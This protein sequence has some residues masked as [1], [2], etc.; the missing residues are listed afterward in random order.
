MR[1][2]PAFLALAILPGCG[3]LCDVLGLVGA[4]AGSAN[5]TGSANLKPFQSEK[6]LADYFV[7]QIESRNDTFADMRFFGMSDGLDLALGAEGAAGF[8]DPLA[9]PSA[10]PSGL[11]ETS[12]SIGPGAGFSQTTIQEVGVDEADVVKTDGN[13]LYVISGAASGSI[14][15]IIDVST[16]ANMAVLDEVNL[17]GYGSDI[18][19]HDGKI[20][21]VTQTYGQ[22]FG[23]GGP[24]IM[25]DALPAEDIAVRPGTMVGMEVAEP[26]MVAPGPTDEIQFN[27]PQTIVTVVDITTPDDATILST[28]RFDGSPSSTRLID[29]VLHLVISNFQDYYYDVLPMLGRPEMNDS[30]IETADLLPRFARSSSG[31]T[32]LEGNVVT[33]RELY[34]PTDADGFGVVTVVSLDV[35]NDAAFTAV[36][37]VAQPGLIYSSLNALYLTDTEYDFTGTVR[38]T[39]DIYKFGY[40]NRSAAPVA[41]GTVPG[42]ILNQY[43][44]SEHEGYLRVATTVSPTFGLL[45][46]RSLPTNNVYVLGVSGGT[47]SVKGRREN[48]EPGE[49]IRSARFVGDRGYMVT[50]EQ[51]DPLLTLDLSDP[52]NPLVMGKLEI[53]GFSTF[54][55]PM[56][57]DH[58]LAVGQHIPD[59]G[60]FSP[61]S[62][63]LSIFDVS[64][65]S[66]PTRTHN[67]V[68]GEM[69]GASSEALQ[70]PKALTYFAE[71]G[72]LAL[73]VSIYEDFNGFGIAIG[74]VDDGIAISP[75]TEPGTVVPI[76]PSLTD[77]SLV[78]LEADQ[79][80]G[81]SDVYVPGGFEGLVVFSVSTQDGF[82][83]LGRIST[84]FEEVGVYWSQF[85]RG[86]FIGDD[87]LAVTDNGVRG[88]PVSD[89]TSVPYQLITAPPA[90]NGRPAR[91]EINVPMTP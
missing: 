10:P 69:T 55:V 13:R 38:E 82:G 71:Q 47:L 48:I 29:G 54:L 6:E 26:G 67:V 22:F 85:T 32:I 5:E 11:T 14:L 37:V 39:T 35:D 17:D 19:L 8:G 83:E 16:R 63:Q 2:L 46:G 4:C 86:V 20:V 3:V 61:W 43:S 42:R 84:R 50:F 18:Y 1:Y 72:L 78:E 27:R 24:G 87:I 68:L 23:F 64:D 31:G 88:A 7:D 21:A 59:V 36:G 53:P 52:S 65:F 62:V 89:I 66:N 77:V 76:D 9:L 28:T 60:F 75:A 44:M 15:R 91:N 45:G 80:I 73:P 74:G 58:L 34:R 57:E 49:T 70:N 90:S 79:S 12:D 41:T 33:W 30:A 51:I 81:V 56:D 25:I 40:R